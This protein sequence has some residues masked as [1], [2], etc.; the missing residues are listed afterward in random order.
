[1]QEEL[2]IVLKKGTLIKYPIDEFN[3]KYKIKKNANSNKKKKKT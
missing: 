1:M 2:I 3:E